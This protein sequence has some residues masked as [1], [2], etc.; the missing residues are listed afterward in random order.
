VHSAESIAALARRLR[1]QMPIAEAVDRVLN[2]GADADAVID[3][4]LVDA[5][6][7]DRAAA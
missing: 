5:C 6:L 2:H 7:F 1:V 4:L 3:G